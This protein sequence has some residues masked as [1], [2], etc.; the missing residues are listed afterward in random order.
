VRQER[1]DVQAARTALTTREEELEEELSAGRKELAD[2]RVALETQQRRLTELRKRFKKRWHQ[3]FDRQR[4]SLRR[5]EH[6]L[7]ARLRAHETAVATLQQERA[8]FTQ[9][10]LRHSGKWS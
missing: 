3:L 1:E 5:R 4:E 2:G 10:L 8:T 9:T 7:A 6:D